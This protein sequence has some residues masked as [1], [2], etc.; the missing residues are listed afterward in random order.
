MKSNNKKGKIFNILRYV[1]LIIVFLI[2]VLIGFKIYKIFKTEKSKANIYYRVYT[3]EDGWSSWKKN[4]QECGKTGNY[5]KAIQIKLD[6][7]QG[8]HVFYDTYYNNKWSEKNTYDGL[9]S[10]ILEENINGIRIMITDDYFKKYSVYYTTHNEKDGWLHYNWNYNYSGNAKEK[11]DKIK[12]LI[13]DKSNQKYE[14]NINDEKSYI[15]FK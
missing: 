12:V 2:V 9:V 1:L 4:G 13:S 3:K 6:K 8:S 7:D 5:I 15:N 10:G 14:R 11:V